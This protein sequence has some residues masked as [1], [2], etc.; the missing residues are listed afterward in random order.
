MNVVSQK[1]KSL[2]PDKLR[3]DFPI[4]EREIG[5]KKLVY[6]DN[7]ATTQKPQVVI[8]AELNYYRMSNANVHRGIH[9]LAEEATR[10]YEDTRDAVRR[11]INAG[12]R[13]EIIF[14]R[15]TTE[16]INLVAQGWGRKFLRKGDR[17]VLSRMEHH[18]NLVPWLQLTNELELDLQYIEIDDKG[19]LIL[20]DLDQLITPKTKLVAIT[21]MSNVLG[22]INPIKQLAKVAHD[23]GAVIL[24]DGAQSVP[25]LPVDV[26]DLDVDFYAFSAHKM[27]GP[28]GVGVLY[29]K[30]KLLEEMDPWQFGGEMISLVKWDRATW[31]EIPHKFEAGT[32][33]IAGV[34]AFKVAL[35]Y[36]NR[37]TMHSIR[38]HEKEWTMVAL[39]KLSTL[40]Y[41]HVFGPDNV[42]ERGSAVSFR[43]DGV[44]PHDL[45]Q[46]LD[47]QAVAV[48]AGHHCAQPLTKLLGETS[49][50]RAS[51]YFYNTIDEIDRLVEALK[52]AK[53]YFSF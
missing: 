25:H 31:A 40:D 19:R 5:E 4:L 41:L 50:T 42:E 44:H 32:P 12:I 15:G 7:A 22:T 21:H 46:F 37:L 52:N 51:G 43:V 45:S 13:E 48:R 34:A 11:F 8:D 23:V 28:T 39:E 36:L 3:L 33:N 20:E 1:V 29:G 27:I 24:V 17:I 26:Q 2:N 16:S 47:S 53:E 9:T 10:A 18:A 38:E 35:D 6:L 30:R 14:T 49:T